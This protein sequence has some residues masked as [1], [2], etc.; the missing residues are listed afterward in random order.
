[1]MV[2]ECGVRLVGL[3]GLKMFTTQVNEIIKN[4]MGV[5]IKL[6]LCEARSH[7]FDAHRWIPSERNGY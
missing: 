3:I 6:L 7:G 2:K 1:M 4:T 5:A